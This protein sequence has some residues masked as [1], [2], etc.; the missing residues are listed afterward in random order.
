MGLNRM[1][2]AGTILAEV[3]RQKLHTDFIL[4]AE[5]WRSFLLRDDEGRK[6]V[7]SQSKDL[8]STYSS[9]VEM[10]SNTQAYSGRFGEARR[11]TGKAESQMEQDDDRESAAGCWAEAAIREVEVGNIVNT[12][13]Y[14]ARALNLNHGRGVLTLDAL[15]MAKG[16]DS[17]RAL[18]LAEKLN[19][20]YPSDTMIQ[21][22]WLPV[23][24]AEVELQK[25]RPSRAIELL[26]GVEPVEMAVPDEFAISVLY[27]AY[28]RGEAY[29]S[30]GDG[31]AAQVEFQKLVDHPGM[32]MNFLLGALA[33]LG[34]ARA[35]AREG[36]STEAIERY[37]E[38]L[39][40]WREADSDV[41][42]LI[43]A[44]AEYSALLDASKLK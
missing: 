4:Q 13:E 30:V 39:S 18:Q 17:A 42:I 40:L 41:P 29:L 20:E 10:E 38:F 21:K 19:R 11:L 37:R 36:N 32:V 33:K 27:P 14:I 3:D 1:D 28:V 2:E 31:R 23:I 44:K 16:G 7:L 12:R 9:L 43:R 24:R 22:Y 5:Y 25:G 35:C 34:S 6:R 15:A 8:P 26:S